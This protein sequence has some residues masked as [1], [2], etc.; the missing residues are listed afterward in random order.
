VKNGRPFI[1][2][3]CQSLHG[4]GH[5]VYGTIL[6]DALTPVGKVTVINAG[7]SCAG[8]GPP[9]AAALLELPGIYRDH[10]TGALRSEQPDLSLEEIR[11]RRRAIC[12]RHMEQ[13]PPAVL[14]VDY[15]PFQRWESSEEI[16]GMIRLA[17]RTNGGAKVICSVRDFPRPASGAEER[18]RVADTLNG[19]F[20]CV[21][22]HGDP[23]TCLEGEAFQILPDIKIPVVG[24][25]YLARGDVTAPSGNEF[26]RDVVVSC[27][28]GA[29]SR[30]MLQVCIE[31]WRRVVAGGE[32]GGRRMTIF[33]GAYLGANDA[34][35]VE[36]A[37]TGMPSVRILPFGGAY[38]SALQQ[39]NLSISCAGDNTCSDIM[40]AGVRAIFI[41]SE[42][43]SDQRARAQWM[44]NLGVGQ[45][46]P[47]GE[48]SAGGL[49]H[50][51]V[52]GFRAAPATAAVPLDGAEF[53]ARYVKQMV[54]DS[55]R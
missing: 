12:E 31:A 46:I 33:L 27:G 53:T 24:T 19:F 8:I 55:A 35:A 16:L 39:G 22:V 30:E 41:P 48:L 13:E 54:E 4:A 40:A 43:V 42:A 2:I 52:E 47:L 26:Q 32:D 34:A 20:D 28:G 10:R 44:Q 29:D 11:N 38:F 37:A 17:R 7:R 45:A 3:Y 9:S 51:I 1:T 50:A 23:D 36:A 5:Y 21:L 25:G 6:G 15:F 49:A 18:K 14:I